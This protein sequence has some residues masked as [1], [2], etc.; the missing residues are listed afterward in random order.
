MRRFFFFFVCEG[1]E[2]SHVSPCRAGANE[3][4]CALVINVLRPLRDCEI[5]VSLSGLAVEI[6]LANV[7]LRHT[8]GARHSSK[9]RELSALSSLKAQ[10]FLP[11][12]YHRYS[13]RWISGFTVVL[14]IDHMD[15]KTEKTLA[16]SEATLVPL[17]GINFL[18]QI[19]PIITPKKR[20]VQQGD[21]F[22]VTAL[23]PGFEIGK[24]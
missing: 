21:A 24:F 13:A 8:S 7:C 22:E 17:D 1:A 4:K 19:T 3:P 23:K 2:W 6:F 18:F 15:V 11:L 5:C 12:L 16:S 10:W 9:N 14:A 20:T